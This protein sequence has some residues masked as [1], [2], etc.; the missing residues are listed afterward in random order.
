[1]ITEPIVAVVDDESPLRTMLGRVLRLAGYRVTTFASGEDFLASLV[2]PPPACVILDIH[3]PGLSGL[4]VHARMR[5]ASIV[6][7]VV[8]MTA[9]D[10]ATLDGLTRKL[11]AHL[12]RKPFPSDELLQVVGSAI[13][14]PSAGI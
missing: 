2:G 7:P 14:N 6:T 4:D 10:D 3:M 12:L 5:A 9:S 13:A 1:M 11:A 8:F